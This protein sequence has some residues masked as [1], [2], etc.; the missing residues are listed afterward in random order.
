[1]R[2]AIPIFA[3]PFM[4]MTTVGCLPQVKDSVAPPV[5]TQ[6]KPELT[7]EE[8]ELLRSRLQGAR[9]PNLSLSMSGGGLRSALVNIGALKA[10]YDDGVLD[11]VDLVSSVSGGSYASYWMYGLQYDDPSRNFGAAAFDNERFL[12]R[13][14]EVVAEANFVPYSR[15]LGQV[16]YGPRMFSASRE[17]YVRSL[18]RTFDQE[19][20]DG[21]HGAHGDLPIHALAPLI[22][23]HRVPYLIVNATTRYPWVEPN[24][25]EGRRPTWNQHLFEFTPLH[26]G[27]FEPYPGR[28]L[29]TQ[30]NREYP[31]VRAV[32]ASG[33]ALPVLKVAFDQPFA[34]AEPGDMT[35]LGDGGWSENLGAIAAFRRGTRA[36]I[37][38]DGEFDDEGKL[39]AWNTLAARL[40]KAEDGKLELK[41]DDGNPQGIYRASLTRGPDVAPVYY[42]KMEIPQWLRAQVYDADPDRARLERIRKEVVS[43]LATRLGLPQATGPGGTRQWQCEN[44]RAAPVHVPDLM[45]F[46]LASHLRFRNTPSLRELVWQFNPPWLGSWVTHRFPETTTTDQSMALDEAL[47]Y[48]ALGYTLTKGNVRELMAQDGLNATPRSTYGPGLAPSR[49]N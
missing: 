25:P 41:R 20:P 38:I 2:R 29:W 24:D 14:C 15:M 39:G 36:H 35:F 43:P 8:A 48:I 21:S 34:D 12:E 1:M 6:G 19:R 47:A 9:Q 27:A 17:M 32:G 40:K 7:Q 10:L 46:H 45:Y 13:V 26:Y 37:V 49:T 28:T 31:W 22:R 33:A 5:A 16:I 30:A 3:L 11:K 42:V 23:E 18:E 4:A 44:L